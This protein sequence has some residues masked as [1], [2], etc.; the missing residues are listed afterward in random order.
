M[1]FTRYTLTLVSLCLWTACPGAARPVP[2]RAPAAA[3]APAPTTSSALRAASEPK[4]IGE[5]VLSLIPRCDG[6]KILDR[7]V[8]FAWPNVE[9]RIKELEGCDWGYYS[10]AQPQAAVSTFYR[11][12]MR[13]PP[14][15]MGET[16][17][18]DRPEGTL[19]LYY[20]SGSRVW[21]Y[22]WVVVQPTDAR[23]SYVIVALANGRVFEP[24]C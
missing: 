17:W 11:E 13:K 7:P 1:R 8:K 3:L 18:V 4:T 16:N 24:D 23:T 12:Q 15:N 20:H 5:R 22:L 10:C 6:I 9:K 2:A 21:I 14:Y 19:G